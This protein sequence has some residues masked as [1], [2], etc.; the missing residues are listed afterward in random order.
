MSSSLAK[1]CD[2]ESAETLDIADL[3]SICAK[4]LL[5][6]A[7]AVN[8]GIYIRTEFGDWQVKAYVNHNLVAIEEQALT[9]FE[10]LSGV[11]EFAGTNITNIPHVF[12]IEDLEELID[13]VPFF[14]DGYNFIYSPIA[15]EEE[16]SEVVLLVMGDKPFTVKQVDDMHEI[17]LCFAEHVHRA[18][19]ISNRMQRFLEE[20]TGYGGYDDDSNFPF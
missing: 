13:E 20:D 17:A 1:K 4:Y 19:N 5:N 2:K 18:K 16:Q 15:G 10:M 14:L 8:L 12:S 9:I 11:A 6:S 7:G 3:S